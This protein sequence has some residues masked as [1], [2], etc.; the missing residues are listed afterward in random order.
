ML[1]K[2]GMRG[3]R[4]ISGKFADNVGRFGMEGVEKRPLKLG[5]RTSSS[6]TKYRP[7]DCAPAASRGELDK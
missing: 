3:I 4:G 5:R 2:A 1:G 7:G 6:V